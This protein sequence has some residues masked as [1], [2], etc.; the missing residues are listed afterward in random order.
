MVKQRDYDNFHSSFRSFLKRYLTDSEFFELNKNMNLRVVCSADLPPDLLKLYQEE[1]EQKGWMSFSE[2]QILFHRKHSN[3]KQF[4]VWSQNIESLLQMLEDD[5]I[6]LFDGNLSLYQESLVLHTRKQTLSMLSTIIRTKA[7]EDTLDDEDVITLLNETESQVRGMLGLKAK[8]S[9]NIDTSDV[10][11]IRKIIEENYQDSISSHNFT[12]GLF[13]D[14]MPALKPGNFVCVW[15]EAKRGKSTYKREVAYRNFK[16]GLNGIYISTEMLPKQNIILYASLVDGCKKDQLWDGMICAD[17]VEYERLMTSYE[18]FIQQHSGTKLYF[19]QT[20]NE[21]SDVQNQILYYKRRLEDMGKPL[22]YVILDHIL[23]MR[24]NGR[25]GKSSTELFTELV[26]SMYDFG[27]ANEYVTITSQH[28][29]RDSIKYKNGR[30]YMP[31]DAGFGTSAME[32]KATLIMGFTQA[33]QQK[34]AKQITA[35]I[36]YSRFGSNNV[37]ATFT[38]DIEH[39]RFVASKV[40][41]REMDLLGL[42]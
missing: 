25:A 42:G 38:T 16:R 33:E 14:Y 17:P 36:P 12:L 24:I 29:R 4:D 6:K 41:Y 37:Q 3:H 28:V 18:N 9:D 2:F 34:H 30:P 26:V 32:K 13:E 21:L 40:H 1:I 11:A 5:R 22:D 23:D 27:V 31:Q 8:E 10:N 35:H 15:A 39:Q 19:V 7:E 20:T